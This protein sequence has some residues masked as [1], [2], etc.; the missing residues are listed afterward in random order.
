MLGREPTAEDV[1]N[2]ADW[3]VSTYAKR[4][5]KPRDKMIREHSDK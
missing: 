2:Y 4:R 1:E 3:Y 5:P